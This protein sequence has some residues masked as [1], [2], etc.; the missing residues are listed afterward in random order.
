MELGPRVDFKTR[1]C[2]NF[3]PTRVFEK[4]HMANN[5]GG[6]PLHEAVRDLVSTQEHLARNPPPDVNFFGTTTTTGPTMDMK[7]LATNH[8][9]RLK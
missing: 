6:L 3:N 9:Q 4:V 8:Q 5:E 2:Q 1:V 7:V